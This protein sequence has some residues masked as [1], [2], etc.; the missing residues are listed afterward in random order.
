MQTK[1][2]QT[3]KLYNDGRISDLGAYAKTIG[4]NPFMVMVWVSETY[5]NIHKVIE[6]VR[7]F[8][9]DFDVDKLAD[10]IGVD[11]AVINRHISIM[12]NSIN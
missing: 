11:K 5:T 7:L 2:L 4:V 1:K 9:P 8:N 3:Q 6:E 10:S 12:D